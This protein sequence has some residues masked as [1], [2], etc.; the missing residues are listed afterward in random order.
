MITLDPSAVL[1]LL[2]R[3]HQHHQAATATLERV[4]RPTVVPAAILAEVDRVLASRL[5]PNA[6]PLFLRGLELGQTLLDCGDRD[7]P[8]IH[9]LMT[10][11]A[12]V[13]LRFAEAAVVVCA[14]RNGGVV[15]SFERASL[16]TVARDV[17]VSILP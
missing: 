4:R 3:S 7:V 8:R 2:D 6:T 17:P 13:P 16:D 10:R 12:R 15:L 9:E 1:A 11:F 14:E 5:G